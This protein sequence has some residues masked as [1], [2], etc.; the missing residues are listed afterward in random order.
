MMTTAAAFE[1]YTVP[2]W[3]SHRRHGQQS[4]DTA[5]TDWADGDWQHPTASGAAASVVHNCPQYLHVL[6]IYARCTK[7]KVKFS[8]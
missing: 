7:Y 4:K 5:R 3:C 6:D 2:L 8:K 1:L